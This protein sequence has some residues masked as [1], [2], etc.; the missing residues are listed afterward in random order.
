MREGGQDLLCRREEQEKH[1]LTCFGGRRSTDLSEK[2]FRQRGDDAVGRRR[3]VTMLH[4][5]IVSLR[6]IV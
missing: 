4:V 3:G 2:L 1:V 5:K 6:Q